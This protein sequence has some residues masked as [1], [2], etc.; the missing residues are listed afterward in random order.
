LRIGR[1]EPGDEPLVERATDL[2]DDPIVRETTRRFLAEEG[3]HLLM[4]FEGDTAMG[5]I[6]G[7][8]LLHPDKPGA[9]MFLYELAVGEGFR[10]RGIGR[11]LIESLTDLAHERGCYGMFVFADDHNPAANATY[12]AAGASR[13]PGQ[14]M[15]VWDWRSPPGSAGAE[16]SR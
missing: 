5:F 2:F 1:L 8:E 11:A 6:S 12:G 10:R 7:I 15:F 4:A 16:L 3:H 9:E 14:V 13:E